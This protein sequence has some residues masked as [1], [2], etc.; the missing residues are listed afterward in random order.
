M[1]IWHRQRDEKDVG[2]DV[3]DTH[4]EV[5]VDLTTACARD[6]EVPISGERLADQ[7]PT[8]DI[9]NVP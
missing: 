1:K 2:N 3:D 6:R 8:Y 4:R 7:E 5:V 9:A